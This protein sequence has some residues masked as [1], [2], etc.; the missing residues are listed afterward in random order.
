MISSIT[1][2]FEYF[3]SNSNKYGARKYFNRCPLGGTTVALLFSLVTF[4]TL[5]I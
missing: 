5:K 1:A 3:A 4:Q 2:N